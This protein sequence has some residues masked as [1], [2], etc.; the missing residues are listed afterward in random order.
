M[1]YTYVSIAKGVQN[2]EDLSIVASKKQS[3]GTKVITF[4]KSGRELWE[5]AKPFMSSPITK[6]VFCDALPSRSY[7]A[8]G[9]SALSSYG[10]LADDVVHVRLHVAVVGLFVK[11]FHDNRT[12]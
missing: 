6:I 4:T 10:N 12:Y 7:P 3:N 8:A 9:I 5:S 2:L 1:P 11:I